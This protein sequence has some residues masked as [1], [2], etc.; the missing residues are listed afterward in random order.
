MHSLRLRLNASYALDA[1]ICEIRGGNLSLLFSLPTLFRSLLPPSGERDRSA[2]LFPSRKRVTRFKESEELLVPVNGICV[3][4]FRRTADS[5]RMARLFPAEALS[6]FAPNDS[7]ILYQKL[8]ARRE[9]RIFE[10][11]RY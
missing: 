4:P 10:N 3:P 11:L 2:P 6:S 9:R 7:F 8:G 1:F 5:A